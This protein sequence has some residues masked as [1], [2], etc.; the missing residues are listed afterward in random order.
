MTSTA[1]TSV[2]ASQV[3]GTRTAFE[4]IRRFIQETPLG[5]ALAFAV[6]G[7]LLFSAIAALSVSHLVLNPLL[8]RSNDFTENILTPA[9][10]WKYALLGTWERFDT[11]WYIHLAQSGYDRPESVVFYPLYPALI[12]LSHLPPLVAALLIST[13]SSFFF[14]WGFQRLVTLDYPAEVGI[15]ALILY[16]VFPSGFMLFG[17]YPESLLL[18]LVVWS[19][20]FARMGRVLP[21]A[22]VALLAGGAKAVGALVF[23]PIAFIAIR[24]MKW[25]MLAAGAAALAVPAGMAYW[26]HST[27][28]IPAEQAYALYWRTTM[29]LPWETLWQGLTAP[30]SY[31]GLNMVA[32][33][34]VAALALST[35]AHVEYAIFAVAAIWLLLTKQTDPVLQSTCRYVLVVFPAFLYAGR[36]FRSRL[37]FALFTACLLVLAIAVFE[38]FLDWSLIV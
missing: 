6:L 16:L 23:L 27:G 8:I 12:A 1:S 37:A 36:I 2:A 25:G 29:A 19:I 38:N 24:R 30:A 5:T 11:L 15:R 20:Y 10:G 14:A 17:G 4:H 22:A 21:T 32:L 33:C 3:A 35:A 26:I 34:L 31:V 7:R 13:L 18:C 28:R 9:D